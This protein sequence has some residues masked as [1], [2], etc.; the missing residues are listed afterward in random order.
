MKNK[1]MAI[2]IMLVLTMFTFSLVG[3]SQGEDVT[4]TNYTTPTQNQKPEENNVTGNNKPEESNGSTSQKPE[5]DKQENDTAEDQKSETDNQE[6]NTSQKPQGNDTKETVPPASNNESKP[7]ETVLFK[8]GDKGT[9][10]LELQ[11]KLF[12][13]GYTL[14]VDGNYGP[15]TKKVVESF[16]AKYAIEKTG[17]YTKSTEKVLSGIK[18]VRNYD[19]IR[20][21]EQKALEEKDKQLANLPLKEKIKSYLGN[22]VSKVG[23]VYYDLTSGEKIALNENK[24]CV[25]ASTYKV[26]MNM[27]AYDKVRAGSLDLNEGLKY[28]SKFFEGGTGILQGQVNTTLKNPVKVQKL[29]D[30][31]ITHSD[32]IAT[33]MIS[34]RLGGTQAVR[35]AVLKMT[36]ISNVDTVNNRT[37]AEVQF[38]LLKKLYENRD[39]KYNAHLISVMKQTVFHDRID[40]YVPKNIVA[41]KIGNYGSYT[42][43]IGI[44]FT[45]KPYIFVMYVDGL[46]SSAEKIAQ[47]SKMVYEAQLKK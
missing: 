10:V 47:I 12:N 39:D 35:K 1:R 4:S 25:A 42:N 31:A 23:F 20:A 38:R 8:A 3:C 18:D 9:G 29:L 37:T 5:E 6:S 28:E 41:H 27:V 45:D 44:V 43:D 2:C 24:V 16:Q 40:K 11:K 13:I 36:G 22:G 34:R 15:G 19:S 46:P 26:G 14:T 17:S 30:L 21:E 33:N 7:T 32:N